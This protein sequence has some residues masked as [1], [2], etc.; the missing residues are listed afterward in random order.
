M[1]YLERMM[2]CLERMMVC[3]GWELERIWSILRGQWSM[4]DENSRG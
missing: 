2:V 1:V 4:T 3:D